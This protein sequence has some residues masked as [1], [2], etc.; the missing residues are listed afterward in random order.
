MS[1][2]AVAAGVLESES[3]WADPDQGGDEGGES[4]ESAIGDVASKSCLL[5]LCELVA[6]RDVADA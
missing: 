1:L 2:C 6:N 4:D 5:L 3:D